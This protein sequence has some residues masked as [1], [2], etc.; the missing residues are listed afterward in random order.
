M[1]PD[2]F[3]PLDKHS[4]FRFRCSPEN[5]CFN[6]CCRDLQ[7]VLTPHDILCLRTFLGISSTQFLDQYTEMSSGPGTGL[8]VVSLRFGDSAHLI[9][10]FVTPAGCRVYP[11]RPASCRTYPLA[12]G[13]SRNRETGAL[14]EHW[15]LIRET[16]C[17]GFESSTAH[18]TEHTIDT[19]IADQ[20]MGLH[21]E[22]NDLLLEL[23]SDKNRLHPEPLTPAESQKVYTALYDLDTFR[24]LFFSA[25]SVG[26]FASPMAADLAR[27]DD[28]ALL[29]IAMAWVRQVIFDR[30]H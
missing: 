16:H 1:M 6:A 17:L 25:P 12:R 8:P 7:Q 28:R 2:P 14:T 4:R 18:T 15:A 22:I 30:R 24:E 11:A 21:N 23:I 10:P 9:C 5:A 20:D 19:W 29:K 27:Q 3:S 26:R 13:V